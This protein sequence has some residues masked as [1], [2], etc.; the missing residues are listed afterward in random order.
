[1][2]TQLEYNVTKQRSRKL[3]A[4]IN[5]L[6]YNFQKVDE[7]GNV[8]IGEP[9]FTIST[10]SDIRRTCSISLLP[11]DRSFDV[12]YGNKIWIDKYMQISIGIED[13]RTK[14]IA[15]T[16]MGIYMIENPSK[17]YSAIDNTFTI[18]GIDLMAKLTGLRNGNIEGIPYR[19]EAG[20]N[21]RNAMISTLELGGFTEYVIDE[22]K[23]SKGN[24]VT[25]PND[26]NIDVGG[27]LYGILS[28]LRDIYPNYEIYFDVNGVFH[29]HKIPTGKNE[30][31]RVNDDLWEKVLVSYT[32]NY[33]FDSIKNSITVIGKTHDVGEN[34]GNANISSTT[35]NVNIEG[36]T[37]LYNQL[38]IGFIAPTKVTNPYININSFGAKPLYE[39]YNNGQGTFPTLST[40]SNVYYVAR[41]QE[42]DDYFLF[43]G[44]VTP[45]AEYKEENPNSPFWINGTM[46]EVRIVLSG[47]EYE[48]IYTTELALDRAKWELYK[49]CRLQDSITISCIPIYWLDVNWLVEITLPNKNGKEETEKYIIKSINTVFSVGGLQSIQLMKY[50]PYYD[51]E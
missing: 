38:T 15:Y 14:E 28:E 35:Y 49:R 18:Q 50:Y 32:Q 43:L 48:N 20:S 1:M 10:D 22:F 3:Y 8:V 34:F 17:T 45:Q 2:P 46:G 23:D 4:Q 31:I 9:S 41:Y 51:F 6:N 24:I 42:D 5:L 39:S 37:S 33:D 44:E 19:V 13:V 29:C 16:D 25:V 40:D 27:T 26:I 21:I 11:I 36:I 12:A 7:W 47:G 30:Q